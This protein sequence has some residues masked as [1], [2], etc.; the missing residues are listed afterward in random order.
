MPSTSE[1]SAYLLRCYLSSSKGCVSP[2]CD[3]QHYL[4][5]PSRLRK[6]RLPLC[7]TAFRLRRGSDCGE[8]HDCFLSSPSRR[9]RSTNLKETHEGL[10]QRDRSNSPYRNRDL[11]T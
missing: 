3:R 7:G 11:L 1:A 4:R 8:F 6:E 10:Q 9:T 5:R 2:R